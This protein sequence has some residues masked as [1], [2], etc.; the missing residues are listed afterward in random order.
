M[1]SVD[2]NQA[3]AYVSYALSDVSFIFPITPSS[4]MAENADVWS[5]QGRKNVFGQV[6]DVYEMESE[7][8]ASGAVH[9]GCAAGS[10]VSTYTCS[11]GLMLMIPNMI[12]IAGEHLPCVFHVTA[13]A[14]AGQALSI[15]GDH[16]DVMACRS[17]GFC[18][19]IITQCT[20]MS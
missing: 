19:I 2:G 4:P 17:T 8:G 14:L 7:A 13:R 3:A 20:T 15:F 9:G 6:V 10:L 18:F 11:Q 1:Q 5:S 12:K 16:S